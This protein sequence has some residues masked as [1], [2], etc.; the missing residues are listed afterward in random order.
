MSLYN[1]Y[2]HQ[3][4]FMAYSTNW[5]IGS[6]KEKCVD[7]WGALCLGKLMTFWAQPLT[8]KEQKL[9]PVVSE[10]VGPIFHSDKH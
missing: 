10:G 2:T 6:L 1:S 7:T 4:G 3:Q 5:W 9:G 8:F